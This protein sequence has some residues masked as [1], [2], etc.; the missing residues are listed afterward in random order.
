MPESLREFFNSYQSAWDALDGPKIAAHYLPTANIYDGDGFGAF[1]CQEDLASKFEANCRA[2]KGFGYSGSEYFEEKSIE[3][4][5]CGITVDLG[6]R[7]KLTSGD[8]SFRTTYTCLYINGAW[9]IACAVAYE[10]HT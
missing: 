10:G 5:E 8:R 2:M 7:V 6:W 4:G 3:S 9:R 1:G